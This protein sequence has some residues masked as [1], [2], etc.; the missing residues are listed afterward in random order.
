M[1]CVQAELAAYM[2]L[3]RPDEEEYDSDTMVARVA[4]RYRNA[5]DA[6]SSLP[7]G[8]PARSFA[9]GGGG[10]AASSP[11]AAAAASSS[12][13]ASHTVE[14]QMHI[15]V[16]VL[17]DISSSLRVISNV[18]AGGSRSKVK[19]S[20]QELLNSA[21]DSSEDGK[22]LPLWLNA[23]TRAANRRG[24]G[25]DAHF[26]LLCVFFFVCVCRHGCWCDEEC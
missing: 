11:S 16:G 6:G 14:R 23:I 12:G 22:Q 10:G 24:R 21:A 25:F 17:S 4:V 18:V 13:R 1:L 9:G 3:D 2:A 7:Y 20:L 19:Q 5:G 8:S 15:M 26:L